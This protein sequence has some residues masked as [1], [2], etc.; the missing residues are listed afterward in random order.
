MFVFHLNSY[1]L[2]GSVIG[3]PRVFHLYWLSREKPR[4]QD[5]ACRR[6]DQFSE[7]IRRGSGTRERYFPSPLIGS[8]GSISGQFSQHRLLFSTIAFI[9]PVHKNVL[10]ISVWKM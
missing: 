3:G 2:A 9:A 6:C 7:H 10:I 8:P 1:Q 4:K 5:L